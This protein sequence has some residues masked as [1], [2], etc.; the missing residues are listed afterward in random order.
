MATDRFYFWRSYHEALM[1]LPSDD[2]RGRFVRAMGEWAF[3]DKE[4]QFERGTPLSFAWLLVRDQL[5]ESV[6]IGRENSENGRRGGRPKSGAKSGGKTTAKSGAKS[7]AKSERKGTEVNGIET[8]SLRERG[9]SRPSAVQARAL[10][11]DDDDDAKWRGD[12]L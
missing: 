11:P 4:P 6:R 9:A 10:A 1:D 7:P 12:T 2:D 8:R 5:T 3:E